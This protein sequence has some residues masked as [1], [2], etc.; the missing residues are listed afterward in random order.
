MGVHIGASWHIRLNDYAQ[1]LWVG[2]RPGVATQPVPKLL[3]TIVFDGRRTLT[4]DLQLDGGGAGDVSRRFA[5]WRQRVGGAARVAASL[6][7]VQPAHD[8]RT[9]SV[10]YGKSVPQPPRR[11]RNDRRI[12]DCRR[13]LKA[14]RGP[15]HG[16]A[17]RR[18][19]AVHSNRHRHL[20]TV[21]NQPQFLRI[22]V[23]CY[24]K[25]CSTFF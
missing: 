1:R 12:G 13:A 21:C 10:L 9:A 17:V 23:L 24:R 25:T 14:N 15:L 11:S 8:E 6:R 20:R 16:R 3:G 22:L 7:P 19:N 4:H 2:L 5:R 18:Q